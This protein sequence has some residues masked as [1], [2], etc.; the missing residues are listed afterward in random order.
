MIESNLKTTAKANNKIEAKTKSIIA[1]NIKF[2]NAV[3][4]NYF[5]N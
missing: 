5:R 2:K 1:L 4:A 3:D